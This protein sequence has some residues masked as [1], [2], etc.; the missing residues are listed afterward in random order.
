[1]LKKLTLVEGVVLAL[2]VGLIS[3]ILF[4]VFAQQ[5]GSRRNPCIS[6][7]KQLGTGLLNYVS[8]SNELFPPDGWHDEIMPYVMRESQFSC[9][10]VPKWGYALNSE[11]AGR[12]STKIPDPGSFPMLFET[13]ALAKDV[14]AN[15]A[16]R[17]RAR[18]GRGSFITRCDTS[19][20]YVADKP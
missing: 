18:H 10:Q 11:V 19:T 8:D 17:T 4:P 12:D 1:M 14:I 3:A 15:L 16:A 7:L 2:V 5:K 13:D 9:D 20:K 6:H